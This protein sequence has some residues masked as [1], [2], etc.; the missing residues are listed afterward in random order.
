VSMPEGMTVPGTDDALV[1]N[2]RETTTHDISANTFWTG[3]KRGVNG[4]GKA[5]VFLTGYST[6][7]MT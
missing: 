5:I 6:T 3:I 1:I 7:C 2:M 4:D